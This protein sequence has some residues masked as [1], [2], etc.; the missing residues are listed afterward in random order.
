MDYLP[1]LYDVVYSDIVCTGLFPVCSLRESV[2]RFFLSHNPY[3]V[4][5]LHDV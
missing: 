4:T 5:L 1:S 3:H 2:Q